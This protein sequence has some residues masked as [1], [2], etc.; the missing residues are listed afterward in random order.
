MCQSFHSNTEEQQ[1]QHGNL[2]VPPPLECQRRPRPA[3]WPHRHKA[4]ADSTVSGFKREQGMTKEAPANK[5]GCRCC[6]KCVHEP[7]RCSG[8]GG[9]IPSRNPP[10]FPTYPSVLEMWGGCCHSLR[11][12][13]TLGLHLS[14]FSTWSTSSSPAPLAQ[15]ASLALPSQI[16]ASCA[17]AVPEDAVRG[18]LVVGAS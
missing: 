12:Q 1:H 9:D 11:A 5:Q 14:R 17:P 2:S 6:G 15:S 16:Q 8:A 10:S 7:H 3:L 18:W 13:H 4:P